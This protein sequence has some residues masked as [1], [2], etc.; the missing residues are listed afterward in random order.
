MILHHRLKHGSWFSDLPIDE[1]LLYG[2]AGTGF[3]YRGRNTA[4]P[5]FQGCGS[6]DPIFDLA[7]AFGGWVNY[8]QF[9]PDKEE[10]LR[11]IAQYQ[12]YVGKPFLVTFREELSPVPSFHAEPFTIGGWGSIPYCLLSEVKEDSVTVW[13]HGL[14]QEESIERRLFLR[15]VANLDNQ[16]LEVIFPVHDIGNEWLFRHS[17]TKTVNRLQNGWRET[18]SGMTA[19][20]LFMAD[21]ERAPDPV[22]WRAT[23]QG[24]AQLDGGMGRKW[25][26]RFLQIAAE[27]LQHKRLHA[28]SGYYMEIYHEW[29]NVMDALEQG[30]AAKRSIN[31]IVAMEQRALNEWYTFAKTG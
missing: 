6:L 28:I 29:R 31:A 20:H 23:V 26:A 4:T 17:M 11:E 25:N 3:I 19:L 7:Q 12:G 21:I 16:V 24:S 14:D 30:N 8:K 22:K 27:A 10:G 9:H 2:L 1:A 13:V 18:E 15:S 5:L